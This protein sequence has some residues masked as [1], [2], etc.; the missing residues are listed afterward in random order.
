[1]QVIHFTAESPNTELLF[2]TIHSANQLFIYGAPASWCED[3]AQRIPG[4]THVMLTSAAK[5]NDQLSHKFEAQEVYSLVQTPRTNVPAAGGRLRVHHERFEEL[6]NEIQITKACES[7]GFMRSVSLEPKEV[8]SLVQT[9]GR[10]NEA[11]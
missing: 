6:S 11:V 3:L 8:D 10:N 9:P 2:R 5:E 1:M 7:V 4:Q